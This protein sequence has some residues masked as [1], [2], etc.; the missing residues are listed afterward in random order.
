MDSEDKKIV[1]SG[2]VVV[3]VILLFVAIATVCGI[4]GCVLNK[5]NEQ[6]GPDASLEKYEWF[7]DAA[8][9]LDAKRASIQVSEAR[10]EAMDKQYAGVPRKD[11]PRADLE[12]SNLWRSEVAGMKASFN[13]LAGQYNARMVKINHAYAN[14][15]DLPKGADKP[16]PREFKPYETK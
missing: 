16:L 2:C 3:V 4:G 13:D 6:V 12:Q 11:W 1:A 15:G 7:K 10:L 9:R 5:V 8:A 14:V